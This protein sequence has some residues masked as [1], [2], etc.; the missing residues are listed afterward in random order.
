[1]TALISPHQLEVNPH[2][3]ERQ[4]AEGTCDVLRQLQ[5]DSGGTQQDWASEGELV[6]WMQVPPPQSPQYRESPQY[7]FSRV[8]S[9]RV[10]SVVADVS[11]GAVG[12][13]SVAAGDARWIVALIGSSPLAQTSA[14]PHH[15]LSTQQ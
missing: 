11:S 4:V 1:M 3:S 8:C 10:S 5:E 9:V 7:I 2:H 13:F 14:V 15:C 6:D 12:V